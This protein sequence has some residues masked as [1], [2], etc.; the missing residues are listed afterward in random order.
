MDDRGN[1]R[2]IGQGEE[3]KSGEVAVSAEAAG[4]LADL[5][6]KARREFYK[7]IRGGHGEDFAISAALA[8]DGV[9]VG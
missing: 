5:S 4:E 7:C 3:L 2:E 8:V 6:K 1:I 9:R